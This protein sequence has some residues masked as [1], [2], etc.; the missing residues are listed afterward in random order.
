[1]CCKAL[2]L[3]TTDVPILLYDC[4]RAVRS[5]YPA[6][7]VSCFQAYRCVVPFSP[8]NTLL[9]STY[10]NQARHTIKLRSGLQQS[11]SP[12]TTVA[13]AHS[14][15]V[16]SVAYSPDGSRIVSGSADNSIRLWDAR[17]GA[18][19]HVLLSHTKSVR[20][21]AFSPNGKE[22]LS[23][24]DDL[25]V[26][27]W[28]AST[29]ACLET[30]KWHSGDVRSVVYSPLGRHAASAS[31]DSKVILWKLATPDIDTAIFGDHIAGVEQVVFSRDGTLLL[32]AS[33]DGTSNVW[34]VE[35]ATLVQTLKHAVIIMSISVSHDDQLIACGLGDNSTVLWSRGDWTQLR[36][37]E[38]QHGSLVWAVSFS[39]DDRTLATGS[40][41]RKVCFWDVGTGAHL[42]TL[43]EHTDQVLSLEFSPDGLWLVTGSC[44]N[45]LRIWEFPLSAVRRARHSQ[46]SPQ[47]KDKSTL[48][49]DVTTGMYKSSGPGPE[50][51]ASPVRAITFAPDGLFLATAAWGG[52]I[53]L[54]DV[55]SGRRIKTLWMDPSPEG[56][57]TWLSWS[58][59]GNIIASSGHD[60]KVRIWDV[61]AESCV[62]TCHGHTDA[63]EMVL[64]MHDDQHVVSSAADGTIRVWEIGSL[65]S[66][67]QH[68]IV[69]QGTGHVYS[70]ALSNDSKM[71][72]SG[73]LDGALIENRNYGYPTIRL[74]DRVSGDVLWTQHLPGTILSLAFSRDCTRALSG[75]EDGKIFVHD[76]TKILDSLASSEMDRKAKHATVTLTTLEAADGKSIE[77]VSFSTD[78]HAVASE[79]S[80]TLLDRA[81]R[82][83]SASDLESSAPVCILVDGWLWRA[84]PELCRICWIPPTYRH[85]QTAPKIYRGNM[86]TRDNLVAF[87]TN[88]GRIVIVDASDC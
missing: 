47:D 87:G 78:E 40:W 59:Q 31:Y 63:V 70:I 3:P 53:R 20:S 48:Y 80:F 71:I 17:T 73:S 82:P 26:K 10:I 58:H 1:M 61:D 37:L 55:A 29:G 54:W 2:P 67:R 85:I 81:F 51:H 15:S 68:Q 75:S 41:D 22:I 69:F 74:H 9:H 65:A 66:D 57:T 64:F 5:F 60:K 45:S 42:E 12:D 43:H 28:D 76:L 49:F 44:D 8:V 32:S 4:E 39:P 46:N 38:G 36:V 25:T 16:L 56:L 18:Q 11:W 21:V 27:V 50:H 24:S 79:A 62:Q 88:S 6:L 77:H 35:K 33:H 23:G 13:E 7:S 14:G 72:L 84:Q 86:V 19:L 34:D 52:K 30:W 83:L